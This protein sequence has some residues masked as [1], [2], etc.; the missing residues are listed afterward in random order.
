MDGE[1][2]FKRLNEMS[3]DERKQIELYCLSDK[4]TNNDICEDVAFEISEEI[5][6]VDETLCNEIII[7]I[8]PDDFKNM[9]N[10]ALQDTENVDFV[11]DLY[12]FY[13]NNLHK[14]IRD[15]II[16][17]LKNNGHKIPDEI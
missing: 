15:R 6:S 11:N 4:Y 17:D 13:Y 10:K 7:H 14:S 16:T 3:E 1:S 9:Q 5:N 8:K 12:E 2:W